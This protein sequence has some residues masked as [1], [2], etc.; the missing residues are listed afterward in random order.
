MKKYKIHFEQEGIDPVEI[1]I[2]GEG[3]NCR[4]GNVKVKNENF[5]FNF[6]ETEENLINAVKAKLSKFIVKSI[7]KID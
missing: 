1:V 7:E 2:S 5:L 4:V 3:S 6:H